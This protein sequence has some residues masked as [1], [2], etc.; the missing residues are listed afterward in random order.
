M[1]H[2][3]IPTETTSSSQEKSLPLFLHVCILLSSVSV[4]IANST[5]PPEY[6][7]TQTPHNNRYDSG[8]ITCLWTAVTWYPH[9]FA[10][11]IFIAHLSV[12]LPVCQLF[13]FLTYPEPLG[14]SKNTQKF[15]NKKTFFP[16]PVIAN[17]HQTWYKSSFSKGNLSLLKQRSRSFSKRRK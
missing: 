11:P 10:F 14:R 4:V 8:E 16:E 6:Q 15:K 12:R 9:L 13:S 3:A 1:N 5:K 2:L 17:F 7:H